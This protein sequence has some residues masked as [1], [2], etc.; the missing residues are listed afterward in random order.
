VHNINNQGFAFQNFE[1][2]PFGE[3]VEK[4]LYQDEEGEP[5]YEQIE[6]IDPDELLEELG[7]LDEEDDLNNCLT[8]ELF[9]KWSL[10]GFNGCYLEG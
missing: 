4:N 9:Q 7:S 10:F 6:D 1:S 3:G 8:E 2:D 5:T